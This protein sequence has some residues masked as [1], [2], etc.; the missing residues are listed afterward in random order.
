MGDLGGKGDLGGG[1][2][3]IYS[4]GNGRGSSISSRGRGGLSSKGRQEEGIMSSERLDSAGES[5]SRTLLF[6]S[7][8]RFFHRGF[9]IGWSSLVGSNFTSEGSCTIEAHQVT[10]AFHHISLGVSCEGG[11]VFQTQL[12]HHCWERLGAFKV[13]HLAKESLI[14]H[15]TEIK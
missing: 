13:P 7:F 9:L 2:S 12:L 15:I 11:Q 3:K 8:L 1:G 4:R 6:V 10:F 14:H 5:L